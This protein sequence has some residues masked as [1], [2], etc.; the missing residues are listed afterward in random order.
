MKLTE[1][2]DKYSTR[3]S[4]RYVAFE[5]VGDVSYIYNSQNDAVLNDDYSGIYQLFATELRLVESDEVSANA[6]NPAPVKP[7]TPVAPVAQ[8]YSI[9]EIRKITANAVQTETRKLMDIAYKAILEEA[10][11]GGR[12]VPVNKSMT[13]A[14]P[15]VMEYFRSEGFGVDEFM[16]I[17]EIKW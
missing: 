9:E 5:D 4:Q 11:R 10:R 2:R 8:H 6:D 12:K 17:F 1:V 3:Q 13:P 16:T 14:D 15:Q 7:A